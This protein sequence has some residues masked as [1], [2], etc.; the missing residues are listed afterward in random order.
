[1][2]KAADIDRCVLLSPSGSLVALLLAHSL[3]RWLTHSII[4]SCCCLLCAQVTASLAAAQLGRAPHSPPP[5]CLVLCS[6]LASA[7]AAE[8]Q[9]G[10]GLGNAW[11]R[12]GGV[13]GAGTGMGVGEGGFDSPAKASLEALHRVLAGARMAAL[14]L[15]PACTGAVQA[16]PPLAPTLCTGSPGSAAGGVQGGKEASHALTQEQL[17]SEQVPT[18]QPTPHQPPLNSPGQPTLRPTPQQPSSQ[19]PF[20]KHP[21]LHPPPGQSPPSPLPPAACFLVMAGP[22]EAMVLTAA[23]PTSGWTV[24]SLTSAWLASLLQRQGA[25]VQP[26]LLR[27]IM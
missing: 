7:V 20:P 9:Q 24:D 23:A 22:G 14:G 10:Q 27:C 25:T 16:L 11:L 26:V 21:T 12:A 6:D 13:A 8:L 4:G 1:M 19:H 3:I 5:A 15:V 17:F 2:A 18:L